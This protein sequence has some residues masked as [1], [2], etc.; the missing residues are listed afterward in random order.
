MVM[1]YVVR[2]FKVHTAVK[3]GNEYTLRCV[4]S[5]DLAQPTNPH[6]LMRPAE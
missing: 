5:E 1:D 2:L 4:P 6:T 3:E